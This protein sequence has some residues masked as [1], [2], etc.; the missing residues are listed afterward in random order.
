[1]PLAAGTCLGPYEILSLLGAGGM[2]EVYR[3]RDPRLGR[4]V[5]IKVLPAAF[6]HDADRLR[7]FELEARAAGALNHP[8]ILA[9]YDVGSHEGSPYVVSELL[10]GE[11]L[12]QR[13]RGGPLPTRKAV[14]YASQIA[15]GLAAAHHKGIV[16]RDLKPANLFLSADDHIKILDFGLAKLTRPATPEE[17]TSAPTVTVDT[18]PGMVMG[19]VGYM[20]PEQVRGQ[21]TDHR[22]DIFT[23]GAILYEMLTGRRAFQGQSSVE[24]MN[25]ILKEDPPELTEPSRNLSPALERLLRHC[26]EKRP[27]ARFQSAQDLAFA[28]E[29]VSGA[30]S[31][32]AAPAVVPPPAQAR[33]TVLWAALAGVALLALLAGAFVIGRHSGTVPTPSFHQLTFRR[34]NVI[35][36]RFAPDGHTILYGAAW[37]GGPVQLFSARAESPESRHLG[38]PSADVLSI[39]SSGEMAVSLGRRY[40]A[41]WVSRGTLARVPLAGGAPREILEDVQ[42]A[43]WSPDGAR[44]AIVREVGGRSRLEF[45]P[46]KVLYETNGWISHPRVSPRGN[47]IAFLD[48]PNRPDDGGSVA[49]VDLT[50]GKTALTAKYGSAQGLAWSG[51]DEIWFTAA[52]VGMG[53]SLRAVTSAG[54]Q[55]IVT[56]MAGGLTLHDISPQGRVLL[57]VEKVRM[58]IL[59][60]APGET[61]ERELTWLDCS[62]AMDISADGKTVLISEEGAGAGPAYAVYLRKTDGSDAVRLGEGVAH[63]LSPDGKWAASVLLNTPPQLVLL[64]TGAGDP[65]F[66][67]RGQITSYERVTWSHDGRRIV[68]AG[69][70]PGHG[71]RAYV[72]DLAGGKPYP[73]TPQLAGVFTLP[74]SPD[75]QWVAAVNAAYE[76][77]LYPINGGTPRRVLAAPARDT[78]IGWT[79]DGRG[80]FLTRMD[81]FPARI[82]RMSL[83]SGKQEV[84]KEIMPADPVGITAVNPIQVTAD[85]KSYAYTYLRAISELYLAQGL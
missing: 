55:R 47:Q 11:P 72:Q 49:L 46:G 76:L 33:A 53:R 48:H 59:A 84:W 75:D 13:L 29:A 10:E 14:D 62:L 81:E 12:N 41:G 51:P 66:V 52:E 20:S 36:A 30:T 83:S 58:G 8:N 4:Q 27:E 18:E 42:E 6:S 80:L 77:M 79:A 71:V 63:T 25:A 69:T 57:T 31:P 38:L 2:G 28:L 7:R 67:P 39:S 3:A 24:A 26:L 22:S 60:L 70:E 68:F 54:R 65:R 78:P 43:D 5:A 50:S 15:H 82:Y 64:P 56:R 23:F 44:L 21:S 17:K 1:M 35:S 19:T 34:G 61:R 32:S 40:T 16:H 85:G 37:D 73:I 74:L 45:P 9:I